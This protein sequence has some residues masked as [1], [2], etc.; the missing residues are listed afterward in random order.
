MVSKSSLAQTQDTEFKKHNY[1]N[2]QRLQNGMKKIWG[3]TT[4]HKKGKNK[5]LIKVQAP[6]C[7]QKQLNEMLKTSEDIKTGFTRDRN[8]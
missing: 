6:T 4:E 3:N 7:T 2:I 1:K 5:L 8:T